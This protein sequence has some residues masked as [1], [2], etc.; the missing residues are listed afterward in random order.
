MMKW[1][2]LSFAA[3][4]MVTVWTTFI[5]IVFEG[6]NNEL[7]QDVDPKELTENNEMDQVVIEEEELPEDNIDKESDVVLDV[8]DDVEKDFDIPE[9][10]SSTKPHKVKYGDAVGYGDGV[11]IDDLLS[12]YSDDQ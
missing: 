10:T 6:N 9:E 3:I 4:L 5:T 1:I 11:P 2:T 8:T 7:S 12:Q